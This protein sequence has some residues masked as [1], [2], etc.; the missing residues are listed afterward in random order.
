MKNEKDFS[1]ILGNTVYEIERLHETL[2]STRFSKK[3]HSNSKAPMDKGK[4]HAH[5]RELIFFVFISIINSSIDVLFRNRCAM[6]LKRLV[7]SLARHFI[8]SMNESTLFYQR[9]IFQLNIHT[10]L[11]YYL[12]IDVLFF[13]VY[14]KSYTLKSFFMISRRKLIAK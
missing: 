6:N 10:K 13:R 8:Y 12:Y 4:S 9:N 2:T 14:T 5:K 11:M 3:F 1:K 7:T